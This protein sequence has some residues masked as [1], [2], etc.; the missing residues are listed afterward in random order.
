M[1]RKRGVQAARNDPSEDRSLGGGL[2][3]VSTSRTDGPQIVK[4]SPRNAEFT[5]PETVR[6]R[7]ERKGPPTL[8]Y[9]GNVD[10]PQCHGRRR[11]RPLEAA[12]ALRGGEAARPGLPRQAPLGSGPRQ[13]TTSNTTSRVYSGREPDALRCAPVLLKSTIPPLGSRPFRRGRCA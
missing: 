7:T 2:S 8:W 5:Q 11:L 4:K 10:G 9:L 3:S 6:A 1:S 13:G 12:D